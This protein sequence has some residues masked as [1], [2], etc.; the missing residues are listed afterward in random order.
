MVPTLVLGSMAF[1]GVAR[2]EC[3]DS[4]EGRIS[5]FST[6][7]RPGF[8]LTT[9]STAATSPIL[10]HG[11]PVL[12]SPTVYVIWYGNWNQANG[13]DTPAGQKIVTDFLNGIGGSPYFRIN[14]GY[15]TASTQVTGAVTYGGATTDLNSQGTTLSDSRVA[16]IVQRA[17]NNKL[18]P[19]DSNGVYFVLTASNISESS[20]FCTRYCGWHTRGTIASKDIKYSFVGNSARCLSSCAPQAVGPNGNA[21]VDGM[22][23]VIAHELAESTSDPDLN[24]WYDSSGAENADKCAWTFGSFQFLAPNGAWANIQVGSR[25]YMIQRNLYHSPYGDFCAEALNPDGTLRQ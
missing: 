18:L 15:S 1:L 17:I 20:G 14:T 25:N 22:V 4:G 9:G 2:A 12:G 5:R 3:E 6:K 21:G 19:K 10:N 7:P 16:A 13:T 23:S 8:A 11:G 24:A